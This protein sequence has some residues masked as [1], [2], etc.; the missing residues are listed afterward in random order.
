M[1][2]PHDIKKMFTITRSIYRPM[3]PTL[4]LIFTFQL[5]FSGFMTDLQ[6]KSFLRMMD[7][8]YIM[9]EEE[10]AKRVKK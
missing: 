5:L 8:Q 9:E 4:L 10:R 7:L 2:H 3:I 1:P 6:I